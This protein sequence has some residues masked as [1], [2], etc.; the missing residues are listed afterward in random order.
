MLIRFLK[1]YSIAHAALHL[2]DY[3]SYK[4]DMDKIPINLYL[5]FSKSFET[6]VHSTLLEKTKHYDID[7]IAY[8]LI[9]SHLEN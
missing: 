6:L 5:N 1:F 4:I 2:S 8:K 9:E 7:D 3:K